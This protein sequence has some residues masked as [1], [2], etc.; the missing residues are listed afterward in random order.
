MSHTDHTMKQL[1]NPPYAHDF[2]PAEDCILAYYDGPVTYLCGDGKYLA[3][4][5]DWDR[6]VVVPLGENKDGFL[7]G[8]ISYHQLLR[9]PAA[10]HIATLSDET[11]QW[12]FWEAEQSD[13]DDIEIP[14]KGVFLKLAIA[15]EQ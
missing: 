13:I 10:P 15:E 3:H 9:S 1:T 14:E 7:A 4:M 2:D 8:K 11:R 6:Y 12:T 5:L